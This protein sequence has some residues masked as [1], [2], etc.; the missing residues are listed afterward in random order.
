MSAKTN[1]FQLFPPPA[2]EV[3]RS[4]NPF[5]KPGKKPAVKA[6]PGSPIPLEEIK[7]PAKT[8][9][10]LLQIIE[11][12]QTIPPPPP[13]NPERSR[14]PPSLTK[15]A[16]DSMSPQ[17]MHSQ[18]RQAKKSN[19][20]TVVSHNSHS[21]S[22]S[23][24]TAAST[25]SPQSSKSSASPIP[26]RSMFPQFDPNLPVKQQSYQKQTP[27]NSQLTKSTRK[28]PKLT[29]TTSNHIDHVLAP[30]TVPASVLDFPTGSWE[31]E[32]VKYSSNEELM[33]LW[34]T[35]N[36]QRPENLVGTL[37]LRMTKTG[38][39]TFTLGNSQKP[40]YTLQTYSTDEL[41]LGRSDPSRPNN[42]VPIMMMSLE[43]RI[44]REHPNDGL[45]T[46]LFSRLAA[47]L[48]IDQAEE[49][50]KQHHLAPAEAS[51]IETDALK[52]AAAQES[53]RLSWN[54]HQR[55]YE[56]R[57]PSLSR[58]QQPALVGAAGIPLSPVRS[59]SSGMVHITVSAPSSDSSLH[60]PPT[61]I[62]TGP[63]SSTAM[64]AAQ[65]AANPRTS[66][67]PVT[68]LDEPLASLD[69]GTK[70]L[71]I[72]PAAVLATIPSLYAIDSLVAA[73]FAVAVSDEATNPIL[74]DMVLGSPQPPRPTTS[75][76][77]TAQSQPVFQGKLV[78]T[79]AEREDA[80]ESM[81]LASQIKSAQKKSKDS[82]DRKGSFAFWNKSSKPK[83]QDGSRGKKQQNQQI[84]VEEFDLEK[85][86]RYGGGT[87]EGKKLPGITRSI[88]RIL[89][90]GLDLIVK[91]LTLIV[92]ILAWLL[93]NATR[94]V[95]SEKF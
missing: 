44:R 1:Q 92:K 65:Q 6:E 59:Q 76:T 34:E 74:A 40:F 63:V 89:F 11:D 21:S 38:P 19:H 90:F 33:M 82:S 87:R 53:C 55:H 60:Q 91:G 51:E 66:T 43:D 23:S 77:A 81:F 73:M 35:A 12:T 54:R 47:M 28:P 52:R 3:K 49:I 67:L 13:G 17:S 93:V 57:H 10:L 42:D 8:E 61:I 24:Y 80:A 95:T 31:P 27:N 50:S 14:S 37:N 39:A 64:E 41:S 79:I 48:A 20:Q 30:K 75:H 36:G 18:N 56:L 70:T 29:L 78:T 83:P 4:N 62:V 32:E 26:M 58:R 88:L 9:S 72:C 84:V 94:C 2:A 68:D 7:D 86:G 71:S 15:T 16:H 45:V 25:V 22:S 85:Y 5:R 69:F 46:L